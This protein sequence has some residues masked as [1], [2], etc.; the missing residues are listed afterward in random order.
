MC[1]IHEAGA[2]TT[3][4]TPSAL[5]PSQEP[6]L[7]QR[8]TEPIPCSA[9]FQLPAE[10]LEVA[11]MGWQGYS[12]AAIVPALVKGCLTAASFVIWQALSV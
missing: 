3:L 12:N 1:H 5:R 11:V 2:R 8:N 10:M 6:L 9:S 7:V 4:F